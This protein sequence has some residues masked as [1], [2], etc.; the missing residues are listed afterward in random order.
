MPSFRITCF[1]CAAVVAFANSGQCADSLAAIKTKAD[2]DALIASS[3]GAKKQA[4]QAQSEAILTAAARKPHVDAVVD[5]LQK[6]S[7]SFEKINITPEDLK[8]AFG[9]DSALFDTLKMANLASTALGIKAKREVDPFDKAFYD[10]LGEI[11][12]L[13]SVTILH[14]TC[15]NDWLIPI[16]K[17]TGLKSINI[18][19][20]GKLTDEGLAH[21][22]GLKNLER[23]GY[24][25]TQ[26]TGHAFQNFKDFTKL[27]SC[28]F[29]GSKIDDEGIKALCDAFPQL[30]S[31]VLAHCYCTDA[32]AANLAKLTKLKNFEIGSRKATPKC[33]Q[34]IAGLPIEYLQLGDGLD[35][36]E[37]TAIIHD[38]KTLRRL[39]LTACK[40]MSDEQ[41]KSVAGMKQLELLELGSLDIPD[42]RVPLLKEFSFLKTL[43]LVRREKPYTPELQAQIVKLLPNVMVKFE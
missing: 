41:L 17:L 20:Q 33:L 14:T 5:T 9:G 22:A 19:N 40:T 39:T 31:L 18:T 11:P 28:S 37:G 25:G 35:S 3:D 12:Q 26:M 4:L 2:L 21:L 13:E 23:L 38:I 43:K 24:V 30:E 29:R 27:K 10:H 8:Q 34:Y 42:E 36:P 6:A 32:G 16:G 15:Q 1:L 7:G